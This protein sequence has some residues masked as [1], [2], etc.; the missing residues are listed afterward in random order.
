MKKDIKVKICMGTGG[1]AA[2][3][4]D[5]LEAFNQEIGTAGIDASVEK[6]CSVH[7]VGCRGLCAKDVWYGDRKL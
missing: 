2:G 3:G 5:V 7:K 6:F 1:I 4:T